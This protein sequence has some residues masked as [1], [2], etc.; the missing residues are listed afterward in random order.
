MKAGVRTVPRP[1][2]KQPARA[3]KPSGEDSQTKLKREGDDEEMT[4]LPKRG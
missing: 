1:V 3:G 4:N 2:S